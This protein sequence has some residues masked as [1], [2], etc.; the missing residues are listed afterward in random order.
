MVYTI[1]YCV[2]NVSSDIRTRLKECDSETNEE[3]CLQRCGDCFDTEFLIVDGK[4]VEGDHER[5]LDQVGA[6]EGRS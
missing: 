6:M 4:P 1:E 2:Q 5:L 3:I